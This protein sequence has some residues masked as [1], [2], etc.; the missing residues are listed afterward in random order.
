MDSKRC[1]KCGIDQPKTN[2][3]L[4]KSRPDGLQFWCKTCVRKYRKENNTDKTWK[5]NHPQKYKEIYMLS[6][7]KHKYEVKARTTI[8]DHLRDGIVVSLSVDDIVS[9]LKESIICPLCGVKYTYGF[10]N[11]CK[12]TTQSIDRIDNK[13]G[14]IDGNVQIICKS[15]NERKK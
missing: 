10:G 7:N 15:C 13:F 8:K 12:S 3:G 5:Q 6:R 1:S 11:G 2:F 14:L 9:M 4:N